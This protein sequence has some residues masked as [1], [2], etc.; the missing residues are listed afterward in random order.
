MLLCAAT[1]SG[2]SADQKVQAIV[3]SASFREAKAFLDGDHERFVKELI[4]LTEIPAPSFKE[5]KRGAAY[6]EM[7]RAAQL[8]D[9]ETDPEGNVMGIRRGT[10][11]GPMLAVLAHLDTVFPEGTNV[12]VKRNGNRVL[13][14]GVGDDT[15]ALALMLSV[16]RAMDAAKVQTPGDV[17][18]VGNV[19]EEGEGDLRGAK[20]LLQKG[21]IRTASRIYLDRRRVA[22]RHRRRPWQPPHGHVQ[23]SWHHSYGAFGLV[24]PHGCNAAP[25]RNSVPATRPPSIGVVGG[26]RR[27]TDSDRDVAVDTV[28]SPD[29]LRKV[30]EAA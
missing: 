15:G 16:I 30:D 22:G 28:P 6:L 8:S 7:L 26:G 12:A 14:P 9:V 4:A 17:L 24:A 19:G 29:E 20:Y 5:Q 2:Q 10:G 27:S 18:F 11:N 25:P 23:G 3:A 13:A 1:V 21:K